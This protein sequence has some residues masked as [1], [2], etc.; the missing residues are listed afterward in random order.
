M[1]EVHS[2]MVFIK[3]VHWENLRIIRGFSRSK[4]ENPR[5]FLVYALGV[6]TT[7]EIFAL[8]LV[9]ERTE[10]YNIFSFN[11]EYFKRSFE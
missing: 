8:L 2:E 11:D 4:Q 10:L 1:K 3:I 5:I 9:T 6:Y 7:T